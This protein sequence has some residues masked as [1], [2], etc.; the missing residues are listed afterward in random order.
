MSGIAGVSQVDIRAE[1]V[2][3][4][5]WWQDRDHGRG[6]QPPR[7]PD[8]RLAGALADDETRAAAQSRRSWAD[9]S[10]QHMKGRTRRGV[11]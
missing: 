11:R 2:W 10:D 3:T 5:S 8:R 4:R 9:C 1:A 6:V 7:E